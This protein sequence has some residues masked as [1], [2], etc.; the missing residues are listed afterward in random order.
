MR[1]VLYQTNGVTSLM[2]TS[3]FAFSE[4][5]ALVLARQYVKGLRGMYQ[6]NYGGKFI[7]L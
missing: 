5:D 4:N 7:N 1:A 6:I 2:L 3:F